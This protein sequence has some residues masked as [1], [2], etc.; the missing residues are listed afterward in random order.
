MVNGLNYIQGKGRFEP[1]FLQ[2]KLSSRSRKNETTYALQNF[3]MAGVELMMV[4][5]MSKRNPASVSLV[6]GAEND[7]SSGLTSP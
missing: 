7:P 2:G 5:S 4:P 3:S 1:R 6:G